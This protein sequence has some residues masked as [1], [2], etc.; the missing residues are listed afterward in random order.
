MVH[1]ISSFAN[2]VC[3]LLYS[4]GW[5]KKRGGVH[6]MLCKMLEEIEETDNVVLDFIVCTIDNALI[7]NQALSKTLTLT[8]T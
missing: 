4:G 5:N 3:I 8:K 1:T 7:L 2:S 6:V